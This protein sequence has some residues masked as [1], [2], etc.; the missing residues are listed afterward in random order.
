[1]SRRRAVS[2]LT[3]KAWRDMLARKGQFIALVVLIALGITSYVTFQNGYYNLR[4]SLDYAYSTLRFADLTVSAD[5]IPDTAARAVERI[6]GVSAALVRSVADIGLELEDGEQA[7][8]RV[9]GSA[10]QSAKVNAVH[11]EQGRY[12]APGARDE[13]ALS[14]QFASDTKT[15]PGDRVTLLIG[16]QRI[17]VRVVGIGIDP[18]NLYAMQ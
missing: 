7:T 9:I 12:P 17:T 8:A 2:M 5:R 14:T 13:V 1:M 11:I 18:E 3:L 4:A 16:G 10:G 15:R 6:P